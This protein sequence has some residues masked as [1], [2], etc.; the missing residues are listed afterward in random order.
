[1]DKEEGL[2]AKIG[3]EERKSTQKIDLNAP[4]PTIHN[5]KLTNGQ[6]KLAKSFCKNEKYSWQELTATAWGILLNRLSGS[7]NN[8]FSRGIGSINQ[9]MQLQHTNLAKT[10]NKLSADLTIKQALQNIRKQLRQQTSGKKTDK[11]VC[12]YTYLTDTGKANKLDHV[13][14]IQEQTLTLIV[15]EKSVGKFTLAYH[16]GY[17]K[18]ENIENIGNYLINILTGLCQNTKLKVVGIEIMPPKLKQK[19]VTKWSRPT[20]PFL[21]ASID[22]PCQSLLEDLAKKQPTHIAVEHNGDTITFHEL[23]QLSTQL[24]HVLIKRG[25]KPQDTIAVLMDRTPS[26]II[27]MFAIYKAGAIFVPVNP[28]YPNERIE[29]VI[30]DSQAKYI[31]ANSTERL[32]ESKRKKVIVVSADWKKMP[33]SKGTISLSL[34]NPEY[35]AYIIYTSGTTGTPKGVMIEHDCLS[36]LTTWYRDYYKINNTDHASQFASQG[37]DTFICETVPILTLGASVHIADD[38]VKLTPNN[39]FKWIREKEITI[40]DLPTAYAQMLFTLEWP[41]NLNV[42]LLKIGG[43]TCIRYPDKPYTFDIWNCYGPTETTIEATYFKMH[44]ANQ[45]PL[46]KNKG[47]SP[48][49]GKI[50]G[51]GE[52]YLVDKYMN[53]VPPGIAGEILIGG[54]CV[55]S[56][57]Y[58]RDEIT[59][60]KF[61]DNVFNK[62]STKKLYRTGDLGVWLSDGS[63]DFAGRMDNQIKIHG[64]RI[65]LGDV[66]NAI[67]HFPDVREVA[68]LVKEDDQSDKSIIAYIT[69]NFEKER[70]PIQVR[71]LMTV[72]NNRYIEAITEDIS[73]QG[74][75]LSGVNENI[76]IGKKVNLHLKLP[77]KNDGSDIGARLIWKMESRCGLIFDTNEENRKLISTSIDY[78]LSSNNIM[79]IIL[80][81]STKRNLRKALIKKLPEYMIPSAFVTMLKFPVTFSG[82]IDLKALPPPSEHNVTRKNIIAAQTETEKIIHNIWATLLGKK[83]ISMDEN[84]FD[85]GGN[86]LKAAELSIK[87]LHQFNMTIPANILFDLPYIS[88][89]AQYI[90]SK[91]ASYKTI[92]V[93]QEDIQRDSK[94]DENILPA[95]SI[96]ENIRQ[97]GNILLTGAGGFLGISMLHEL[98]INTNAKIFCLIR[99]GNFETAAKRMITTINEYGFKDKITLADRRIIILASDLGTDQFDLPKELYENIAAKVDLI[100]HCGAQVN[101]MASYGNMR[102]SNVIGTKEIIKF[103]TH[104]KNKP[105]NY[106]STL[107]SAYIKDKNGLLAEE[108]P[109][110]TY[111]NLFGGY[112]ISK[113][114]SERMLT[115][116]KD[117]GLP[118]KIY[119]SGY[120]SGDSKTG[121]SNLNDA[122][123][124]LIKGCILLGCAPD[125]HERITILPVDFVSNAIIKLSLHNPLH[126]NI[127]HVDH[128]AGIMW[129]DLVSW[130][131]NYGYLIKTI[132]LKEWKKKLQLIGKDNPLYPF[133]PFYLSYP[134]DYKG[135]EVNTTKT[136][137]ALREIGI[138]YPELNDSLLNTYFEYLRSVGFLAEP[139]K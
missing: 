82:K 25:I 113:W 22:K 62:S 77:G 118:V 27:T 105:I 1:M 16:P 139:G 136:S 68:V 106:I 29:F 41:K 67:S 46:A 2:G 4:L 50:I 3:I 64:Y 115:E 18:K 114:V 138:T 35:T 5:I 72:D 42:R 92:T 39:F 9:K 109:T 84:F 53:I 30:E 21:K 14:Q 125:F 122:L 104:I 95:D 111:E 20:Y 69:P 66:E 65:E 94:L 121:L 130:L 54:K 44:K 55:S 36:N 23:N 101:I 17:F 76:I 78:Y 103:A 48:S 51:N 28:K 80:S 47:K 26:L 100:Y 88:I 45:K 110:E 137:A 19:I 12:R 112:A 79:D 74:V 99:K 83:R 61:I 73:K 132:A 40:L 120:I 97:P 81:A 56:G 116:L 8:M 119:R 60:L 117:R 11:A 71:C 38:N 90:D 87:L 32:S 52:I 98:I 86:S 34:P 133:L 91:G 33:D 135:I 75:A 10:T 89:L 57:Y 24:A 70:Y 15:H 43:E 102:G 126:S 129:T 31:L 6:L 58:N 93:T 128:P 96:A 63:L 127:Y 49:I 107:S 59:Q 108:F 85:I 131:N 134:D 37:F 7:E 124:I 13:I 123:L